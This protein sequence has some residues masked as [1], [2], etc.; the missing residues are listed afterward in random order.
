MPKIEID[1]TREVREERLVETSAGTLEVEEEIYEGPR[2]SR[3]SFAVTMTVP[4]NQRSR[5]IATLS[6]AKL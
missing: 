5:A 1:R 3:F 2:F 4:R 6:S